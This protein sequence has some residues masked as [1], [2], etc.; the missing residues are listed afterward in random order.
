MD[1]FAITAVGNLTKDWEPVVREDASD[2]LTRAARPPMRCG[3][4]LQG[5][6]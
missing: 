3:V 1:S 6:T 4:I 2:A 5:R